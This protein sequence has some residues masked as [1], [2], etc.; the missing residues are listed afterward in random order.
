MSASNLKALCLEAAVEDCDAEVYVNGI[1]L[2]RI[3]GDGVRNNQLALTVNDYLVNGANHVELLIDPGERPSQA[4]S[5]QPAK[6]TAG[7]FAWLRL[8][9]YGA[10]ENIGGGGGRTLR[11]IQYEGEGGE[12]PRPLSLSEEVSVASQYPAPWAWERAEPLVMSGA[13]VGEATRFV[14]DLWHIMSTRDVAG[15]NALSELNVREGCLAYGSDYR[16][17]RAD[18]NAMLGD[19]FGDPTFAMRPL[20]YEDF[21]FRLCANN[22]LIECVGRDGKPVIISAPDR[23]GTVMRV[24]LFLGRINGRLAWLR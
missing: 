23:E 6:E 10:G 24:P 13:L 17:T 19:I 8:A 2:G 18:H 1:P 11:E 14:E 5:P 20:A 7:V 22:R 3:Y 15:Q 4:R 21:D 9:E 12:R 16:Q